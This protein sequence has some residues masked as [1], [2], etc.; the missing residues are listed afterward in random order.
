MSRTCPAN[1]GEVTTRAYQTMAWYSLKPL[2]A[3]APYLG[4]LLIEE[5]RDENWSLARL[6]SHCILGNQLKS[7]QL[8]ATAESAWQELAKKC[9]QKL[10][11]LL[12]GFRISTQKAYVI[13]RL[14][15]YARQ[16]N[17]SN[18]AAEVQSLEFFDVDNVPP[19][20]TW[21]AL[22]DRYVLAWVPA[23]LFG[24]ARRAIESG[25]V[26]PVGR[27]PFAFAPEIGK[28]VRAMLGTE[29]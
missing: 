24:F 23:L 19:G 20:H 9:S 27:R 21:I 3:K 6:Q 22:V 15:A 11:Q 5:Y 14:V 10:E 8:K 17:L 18:H 28:M 1:L 13:G 12:P 2:T 26:H 16:D 4:R 7:W 29:L 25:R